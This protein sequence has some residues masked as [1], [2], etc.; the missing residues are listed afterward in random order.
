MAPSTFSR[1][2]TPVRVGRDIWERVETVLQSEVQLALATTGGGSELASWLLNHPGASRAVVEVQ[3]PYRAEALAAY[4]GFAGPHRVTEQTAREMAGRAFG[5][6]VAFAGPRESIIGVGCTAALAT[7]RERRGEDRVCIALRLA[8]E[9]RLYTLRFEKGAADRLEQEEVLSRFALEAIVEAC[10]GAGAGGSLPDYAEYSQRALSLDD[11]LGLLLAGELDLV[12]M[13]ADGTLLPE[14]DRDNRLLFPGSF[15]PL[16]EGHQRL[17]AAAGRL[18][19]RS[20]SLELS[21]ENVDKPPLPREEVERRLEPLRGNFAVVMTRAPTFLQKAR[22]FGGCHFVV[23]Y[24]TA[25]RLLQG[26]YYEGRDRGMV[27]ALDELAG[28][29]CRFWVAGR[30]QGGVYQTLADI[31]LPRAHAALFAAIPE[32]EFR[33]D[34]SSTQLRARAVEG[35]T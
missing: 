30:L 28:D 15:N 23:G 19:G 34:I 14:V 6:V 22:L 33:M 17:A 5:R 11:P 25:V 29:R 26:K 10:G 7:S 4:L 24:D 3:V 21:V 9:Y 2:E 12:E 31:D 13:S 32:G 18:S 27:A 8:G 1:A 35:N 20:P 16:H